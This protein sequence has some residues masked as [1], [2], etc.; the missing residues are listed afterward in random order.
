[1]LQQMVRDINWSFIN[2]V[3][4]KPSDNTTARKTRGILAAIT[5]NVVSV[6]GAPV[7]KAEPGDDVTL[8]PRAK[9][10]WTGSMSYKWVQVGGAPV[11][12]T[13]M[14]DGTGAATLTDPGDG[15][16]V[17]MRVTARDELGRTATAQVRGEGLDHGEAAWRPC[18]R[19]TGNERGEAD[20]DDQHDVQHGTPVSV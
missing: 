4:Q 19:H 15:R 10:R 8:V 20:A 9:G 7:V 16:V 17:P 3:Y 6:A 1:M 18:T 11:T 2:G 12:V 14:Q 13:P 5:S